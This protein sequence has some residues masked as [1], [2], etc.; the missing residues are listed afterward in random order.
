MKQVDLATTAMFAWFT[1]TW[2]TAISYLFRPSMRSLLQTHKRLDRE[3]EQKWQED[4][5]AAKKES[6]RHRLDFERQ[7]SGCLCI[8]FSIATVPP[9]IV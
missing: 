6:A 5:V 2:C 8:L 9:D 7:V 4:L 3:R 1:L